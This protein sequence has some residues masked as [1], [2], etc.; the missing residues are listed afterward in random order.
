MRRLARPAEGLGCRNP[1]IV[2]G[3]SGAAGLAGLLALLTEP[4]LAAARS[5][6]GLG[7]SSRIV[8]FNTEGDTDPESY[9]RIVGEPA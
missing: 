9:R 4:E 6:I 7:P 3:E 5:H 1:R 2:A 8:V